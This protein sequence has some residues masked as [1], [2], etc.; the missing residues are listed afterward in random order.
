VHA[1]RHIARQ[2]LLRF[3]TRR[4]RDDILVQRC[5]FRLGE[6]REVLQVS[7]DIPVVDIDPELVELIRRSALGIEP[8]TA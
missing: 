8:D 4:I 1:S 2:R 6:K 7:P 3:A 5:D